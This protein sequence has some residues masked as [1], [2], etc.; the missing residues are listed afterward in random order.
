MGMVG[1][2]RNLKHRNLQQQQQHQEP[3]TP[4]W[5]WQEQLS[6][7]HPARAERH[8]LM[9]QKHSTGAGAALAFNSR[10]SSSQYSS[11]HGDLPPGMHARQLLHLDSID[12]ADTADQAAAAGMVSMYPR[13]ASAVQK[14]LSDAMKSGQGP[15]EVPVWFLVVIDP[16]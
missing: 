13:D 12:T 16:K 14:Y 10:D 8:M 1:T 6:V 11:Y 5:N 7:V 3:R 4:T 15:L 2:S 9:P